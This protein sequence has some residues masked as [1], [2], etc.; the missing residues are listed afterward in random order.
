MGIG[1][2]QVCCFCQRQTVTLEQVNSHQMKEII[3]ALGLRACL[4]KMLHDYKVFMVVAYL[5]S[6]N[7]C[8]V[9]QT[10]RPFP[11]AFVFETQLSSLKS[12]FT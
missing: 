5:R 4:R 9:A 2:S 1:S 8:V 10:S 12:S 6:G 7:G 11:F 3:S